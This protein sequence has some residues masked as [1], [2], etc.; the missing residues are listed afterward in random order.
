MGQ[1]KANGHSDPQ[2]VRCA[3]YTRK[4]TAE[5][6]EKEFNTLDAQREAAEAYVASQK[7]QGWTCLPDRYD[8]GGVSGATLERPALQRLLKDIEAERLDCVLVYKV[9]RLSRSLLDFTRLIDV[10]D[11]HK[12]TFVSITQQF[13]TTT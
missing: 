1:A 3:I 7:H 13:Q 2:R 6:L 12:V 5:G 8:D 10:F 11:Q 9:D 4:S